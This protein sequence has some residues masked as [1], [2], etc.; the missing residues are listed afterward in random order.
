MHHSSI[1]DRRGWA[2]QVSWVH[3]REQACRR[4]IWIGVFG[5]KLDSGQAGKNHSNAVGVGEWTVLTSSVCVCVCVCVFGEFQVDHAR[6]QVL[7][8]AL[9][10]R[11]RWVRVPLDRGGHV[12]SVFCSVRFLSA[13]ITCDPIES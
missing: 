6:M 2:S 1:S 3:R 4:G 9:L 7:G 12:H 5:F 11:V 13:C 10:D 8:Y